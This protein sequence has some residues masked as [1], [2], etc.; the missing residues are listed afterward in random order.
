MSA[1]RKIRLS[2]LAV[3]AFVLMVSFTLVNCGGGGGGGGT[4]S[5]YTVTYDGNGK[6]GGSVPV[7]TANYKQGQTV[8]VLGNTG[9][10]VK[11]GYS[12]VGWNTAANGT[13][14]TYGVTFV[15]G[16]ANVTLYAKWTTNSTG[17]TN[18]S[19]ATSVTVSDSAPTYKVKAQ[20]T[21]VLN[22]P[23]SS[24]TVAVYNPEG[25]LT[26]EM[27]LAG[28]T[29]TPSIYTLTHADGELRI[30]SSMNPPTYTGTTSTL[31]WS[32]TWCVTG[33]PCWTGGAGGAWFFGEGSTTSG[34]NSIIGSKIMG[35][36]TYTYSFTRN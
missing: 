14:T 20:V 25:T 36:L 30:D 27:I 15:M 23:L 18:W 3:A 13:G 28:L 10:L 16:S 21:W 5:A 2:F 19:G 7:D 31:A 24:A 33:V 4:N 34:G 29:I 6:T 35:D 26:L 17:S 8:T 12:F 1:T 9:N 22:S 32:A 11:S